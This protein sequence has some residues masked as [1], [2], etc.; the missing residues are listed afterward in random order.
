MDWAFLSAGQKRLDQEFYLAVPPKTKGLEPLIEQD[1]SISWRPKRCA[2]PPNEKFLSRKSSSSWKSQEN[3]TR[4]NG[5]GR[6]RSPPW[7]SEPS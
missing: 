5:A 1:K 3:L 7:D 6:K 2:I 4:C